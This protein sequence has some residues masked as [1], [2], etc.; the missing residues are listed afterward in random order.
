MASI[1]PGEDSGKGED[2]LC[3]GFIVWLRVSFTFKQALWQ[4]LHRVSLHSL[5][6][7]LEF[8]TTR[9]VVWYLQRIAGD[10][11]GTYFPI[12]FF[13]NIRCDAVN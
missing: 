7:A 11:C 1:C 5:H 2:T 9:V 12:P 3:K 13:C 4:R 8:I 6:F 10:M